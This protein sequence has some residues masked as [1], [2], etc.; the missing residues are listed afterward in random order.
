LTALLGL[1]DALT[2]GLFHEWIQTARRFVED[3]QFG[4]RH[5]RG[6][7][8]QLLTVSLRERSDPFGR[9]E[10]EALNQFGLVGQVNLPWTFPRRRSVS[11]PLNEGQRLA[12]P[13]TYA[14]RR[15]AATVWRRVSRP[16]ISARPRDGTSKPS[17]SRII[18]V[19]PAPLGPRQ[20]TIWPS[21]T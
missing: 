17:K 15:C 1:K 6:D 12:S 20:P 2:K 21:S 16:K 10:V 7:E 4:A 8:D 11:A 13:G 19:L 14:S 5:E 9:V 18:V 3:E